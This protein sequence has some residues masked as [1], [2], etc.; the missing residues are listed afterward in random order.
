MTT[1]RNLLL[2]SLIVVFLIPWFNN[3][4]QGTYSIPK[5][6]QEDVSFYEINPCKVSLF[7][8]ISSNTESVYQN[9]FYFRPDNK[10]SIQCFGR[11]S[12]VTVL[13]K[14]LET[15]FFISVGTNSFINLLFQG[16]FWI[17]IFNLIPKSNKPKTKKENSKNIYKNIS[18]LL[19]SYLFT[20]SIYA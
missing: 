6:S 16:F 3:D 17:F 2:F 14:G 11:I 5:V 7:Q 1:K 8:F 13:Q 15:Q 19:V 10:S 9:H 20:Y 18:L 4:A 12:G